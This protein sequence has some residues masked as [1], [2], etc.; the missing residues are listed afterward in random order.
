MKFANN[1]LYLLLITHHIIIPFSFS[2][3]F[4]KEEV[5]DFTY[6]ENQQQLRDAIYLGST[7]VGS[8]AA[9]FT[10][11]LL[12]EGQAPLIVSIPLS[13]VAAALGI[14]GITILTAAGYDYYRCGTPEKFAAFITRKKQNYEYKTKVKKWREYDQYFHNLAHDKQIYVGAGATLLGLL[15]SYAKSEGGNDNPSLILS[16]AGVCII[17][18]KIISELKKSYTS[19]T[20]GNMPSCA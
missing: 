9:F 11:R 3:L 7:L 15:S 6:E 1:L 19:S 8:S 4:R 18:E 20:S 2:D 10:N 14:C 5:K 13:I 17:T 12:Q 16:V